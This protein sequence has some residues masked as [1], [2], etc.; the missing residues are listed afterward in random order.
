LPVLLFT[1]S[2]AGAKPAKNSPPFGFAIAD[3]NFIPDALALKP[4][5][6]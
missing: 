2:Y 1:R 4:F 5:G 6:F 3:Y